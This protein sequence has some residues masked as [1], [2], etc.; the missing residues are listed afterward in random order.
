MILGVKV[1]V[2]ALGFDDNLNDGVELGVDFWVTGDR[3]NLGERLDPLQ[4]N[5]RR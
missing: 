3:V 5:H 4:R 1:A 2:G